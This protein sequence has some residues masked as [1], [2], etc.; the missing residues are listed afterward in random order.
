MNHS[1]HQNPTDSLELQ[2]YHVV[3]DNP[4]E[5]AMSEGEFYS[6]IGFFE[7]TSENEALEKAKSY[8]V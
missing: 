5:I 3:S 4:M 7:A 8:L 6:S 1:E 2:T